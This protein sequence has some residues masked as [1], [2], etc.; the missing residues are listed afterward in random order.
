MSTIYL[1]ASPK[2]AIALQGE[3]NLLLIIA[4]VSCFISGFLYCY[5]K[6]QLIIAPISLMLKFFHKLKSRFLRLPFLLFV[7]PRLFKLPFDIDRLGTEY[8]GWYFAKTKSL[9]SSQVV[10][11][12]AGEDIS[13]DV[14]FAALYS[15]NVFIVDPTQRAVSHVKSVIS[16]AGSGS[17]SDFVLGGKQNPS[18]YDL[19]LVSNTQLHLV[20][21][22]LWN[23]NCTLKFFT[24][25]NPQHVS[26]SIVNYQNSY[27]TDSSFVEVKART[28]SSLIEC[29]IL[30]SDIEIL[31]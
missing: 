6:L 21:Y 9:H 17:K 13:F 25:K 18:S 29:G 12:G 31:N 2:V 8:G 19:T 30:P 20:E 14:A 23:K 27:K 15:A 4:F 7:R 3:L 11:C 5:R 22:A 16:R 1:S 10:F 26:H 28:I 24:P